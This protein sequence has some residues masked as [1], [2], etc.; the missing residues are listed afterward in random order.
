MPNSAFSE[1][2]NVKTLFVEGLNERIVPESIPLGDF[3]KL[4]GLRHNKL[5]ELV[6]YPG[7]ER[8]NLSGLTSIRGIFIFGEYAIIQTAQSLVR[9]R[10]NEL[11]PDFIRTTPELFPDS[12]TP[13]G[14]GSVLNPE[15][16]SYALLNYQVPAG[17]SP[18]ADGAALVATTWNPVPINTEVSDSDNRVSV[19]G[20]VITITAGAYP[21]FVRIDGEVN[22]MGPAN[23][24]NTANSNQRAAVRLKVVA[25]A[26]VAKGP[27]FRLT[28]ANSAAEGRPDYAGSIK[29]RFQLLGST[30]FELQAFV[31]ENSIFGK[32]M[33]AGEPEV[34]A[35]LE[36]IIEE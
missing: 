24:S 34:Y 3:S 14:G 27:N 25:G 2:D 1:F 4:M 31:T 13:P 30:D 21:V 6:R 9:A 7:E 17:V 28:S 8:I 36:I 18:G 19:A 35:Q 32:A 10:L 20:G 26:T 11:F 16:M 33:N 15:D 22:V 5:G 23:I 12:Y 29:G